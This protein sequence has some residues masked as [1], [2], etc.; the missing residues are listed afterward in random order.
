MSVTCLFEGQ[1][2]D[3]GDALVDLYSGSETGIG[4]I[5]Y[6]GFLTS[7]APSEWI[8]GAGP[9]LTPDPHLRTLWH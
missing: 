2:A 6:Q 1:G 7:A 4:N 3:I 9:V 5:T 8:F